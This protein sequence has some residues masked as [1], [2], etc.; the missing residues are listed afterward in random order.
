MHRDKL[1]PACEQKPVLARCGHF[2]RVPNECGLLLLAQHADRVIA[3]EATRRVSRLALY[4]RE[5]WLVP[6]D[7]FLDRR[8]Q[9][10]DQDQVAGVAHAALQGPQVKD[11]GAHQQGRVGAPDEQDQVAHRVGPG[12]VT[13]GLGQAV[14]LIVALVG[15]VH[16]HIGVATIAPPGRGIDDARLKRRCIPKHI[17]GPLGGLI[18]ALIQAH[19]LGQ[20][21]KRGRPRLVQEPDV[22]DHPQRISRLD[23][24]GQALHR[25]GVQ[26]TIGTKR[27]GRHGQ[28]PLQKYRK[29]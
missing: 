21:W 8:G 10:M 3:I 18:R 13:D 16:E 1:L 19:T 25:R 24:P 6:H 26:R 12:N 22:D 17:R 23:N 9:A 7:L 14:A 15:H 11:A 28:R 2:C 29:A 27:I 20:R 4:L 5:M